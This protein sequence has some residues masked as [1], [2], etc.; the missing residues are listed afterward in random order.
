VIVEENSVTI[1][2]NIVLHVFFYRYYYC[3]KSQAFFNLLKFSKLNFARELRSP[4]VSIA[5]MKFMYLNIQQQKN[6][7]V[8][9]FRLFVCI[10]INEL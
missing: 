3:I 5:V 9:L 8:F 2:L 7:H 6:S 1:I 10:A 4:T